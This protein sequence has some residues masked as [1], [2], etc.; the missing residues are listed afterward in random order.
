MLHMPVWMEIL[1]RLILNDVDVVCDCIGE[2][3]VLTKLC[4]NS[5][6]IFILLTNKIIF[7]LTLGMDNGRRLKGSF[8]TLR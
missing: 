3:V 2:E 7:C 6:F 4:I 5:D 8:F 1:E